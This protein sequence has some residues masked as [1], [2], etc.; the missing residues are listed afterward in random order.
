MKRL[1]LLPSLLLFACTPQDLSEK[2]K[3]E[4]KDADR[5]MSKLAT[6]KGFYSALLD[7]A[8]SNFVKFAANKYPT[9]G[10]SAFAE[11]VAGKKEITTITWEPA[12]ADA[13]RSG[14]IGYSWGNW[15]F[16]TPDT[17]VYGIYFTA[18]KKNEKGEWKMTIDGGTDTPAPKK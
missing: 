15:N 18:W 2:A 16:V 3:Q 11:E 8:D 4:I 10:K 5:A 1:L 17:T 9:I 13:A 14:E 6:E 12:D 7:Y